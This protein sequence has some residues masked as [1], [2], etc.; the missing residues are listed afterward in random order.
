MEKVEKKQKN[1]KTYGSVL[2]ERSDKRSQRIAVHLDIVVQTH[3][4]LAVLRDNRKTLQPVVDLLAVVE[5]EPGHLDLDGARREAARRH[6]LNKT[7]KKKHRKHTKTQKQIISEAYLR[8]ELECG[9]VCRIFNAFRDKDE[10][11]RARVNSTGLRF[12]VAQ[13]VFVNAFAR[14]DDA[15]LRKVTE[16]WRSVLLQVRDQPLSGPI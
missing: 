4:V 15:E 1:R 3:H 14:H 8:L 10:L 11:N 13:A 6:I 12:P 2:L 16:L 9:N 5:T 7:Y